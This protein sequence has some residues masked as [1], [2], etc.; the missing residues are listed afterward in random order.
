MA[1][2]VNHSAASRAALALPY[3][4]LTCSGSGR[5]IRLQPR[6]QFRMRLSSLP[7]LLVSVLLY[8]LLLYASAPDM[9]LRPRVTRTGTSPLTPTAR[10]ANV[11]MSLICASG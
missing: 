5:L 11:S 8:G 6:G 4:A 1:V 7:R 10:A 9:S 2:L 3:Q